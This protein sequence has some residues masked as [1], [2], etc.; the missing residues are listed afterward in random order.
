MN[1]F[2]FDQD[3]DGINDYN[4]DSDLTRPS[5]AADELKQYI[6]ENVI[7]T[8]YENSFVQ[9]DPY[10]MTVNRVLQLTSIINHFENIIN[11]YR[12]YGKF[13][14][15]V[16]SDDYFNIIINNEN[17]I[18]IFLNKKCPG[19]KE[20]FTMNNFVGGINYVHQEIRK[21]RVR[22]GSD[23]KVFNYYLVNII[24]YLNNGHSVN[25]L[26]NSNPVACYA[27]FIATA[28]FYNTNPC[29]HSDPYNGRDNEHLLSKTFSHV[30]DCLYI[31]YKLG[32]MMESAWNY[33]VNLLNNG[34][35]LTLPFTNTIK[36]GCY[37][38]LDKCY[39]KNLNFNFNN[40]SVIYNNISNSNLGPDYT[41]I[42]RAFFYD[43][44]L[45]CNNEIV[46]ILRKLPSY[47]NVDQDPNHKWNYQIGGDL[48]S[49]AEGNIYIIDSKNNN[50][51]EGSDWMDIVYKYFGQLLCYYIF[52]IKYIRMF[53]SP[54]HEYIVLLN[55]S[56]CLM[57]E[58][59]IFYL[60]TSVVINSID[61]AMG[62]NHNNCKN[63]LK[64]F[65]EYV[66]QNTRGIILEWDIIY[67]INL[68]DNFDPIYCIDYC[69]G[70]ANQ[71]NQ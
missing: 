2:N 52:Y 53:V 12:T 23:Y 50:N 5:D 16:E 27:Y 64:E 67:I 14:R 59:N 43:N 61:C 20:T 11:P 30:S 54:R 55:P 69:G 8:F 15:Y 33:F 63:I 41:K 6:N 65:F 1:E 38:L 57:Y 21:K 36:N 26:I 24:N 34:E 19:T 40:I 47:K 28:V 49:I 71:N 29:S 68:I 9:D 4:S 35:T 18:N 13:L 10:S 51:L 39:S 44:V 48:I 60:L 3:W 42:G 7:K 32:T 62:F 37:L 45:I 46:W 31:I 25:S 22:F 66:L 58:L 70:I 17:F 56:E